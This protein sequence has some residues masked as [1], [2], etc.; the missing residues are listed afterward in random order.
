MAGTSPAMTEGAD[1]ASSANSYSSDL[2]AAAMES[3]EG[4]TL[5]S[6]GG[7]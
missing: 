7:L 2:T 1:A 6:S 4:S 3:G 5:S